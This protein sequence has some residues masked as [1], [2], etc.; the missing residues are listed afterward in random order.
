MRLHPTPLPLADGRRWALALTLGLHLLAAFWWL[1]ERRA[2]PRPAARDVPRVVTILLQPRSRMPA[3][4]PRA[5]VALPPRTPAPVRA[6]AVGAPPLPSPTPPAPADAAPDEPAAAAAPAIPAP[7]A[8][9]AGVPSDAGFSLDQARRQ[10]GRI[11]RE[12]RKGA[13]GVPVAAD[14]PMARFRDNLEAAHVEPVTG[15]QQDSYT[16]PD[17]AIIYRTRVGKRTVCRISGSVGLGIAGAR[18]INDAGSV[19]CP[20]GVEWQRD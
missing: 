5:P 10:A 7:P 11:D 8:A 3:P 2:L 17:G 13:S 1:G 12:L 18:G 15:V 16:A 20:R 4:A 14:T 19:P 9:P 6:A